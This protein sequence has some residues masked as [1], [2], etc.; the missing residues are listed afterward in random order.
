MPHLT[1]PEIAARMGV[2]TATAKRRI[3]EWSRATGISPMRPGRDI[4]LTEA[5][6][7]A[8]MEFSRERTKPALQRE[9]HHDQMA[10]DYLRRAGFKTDPAAPLSQGD[11]IRAGKLRQSDIRR[12]LDS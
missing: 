2:S 10:R 12:R 9:T 4:I 1:V 3:A 6:F 7:S 8:V 5:E 11:R